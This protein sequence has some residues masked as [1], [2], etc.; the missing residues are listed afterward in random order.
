MVHLSFSPGV[1]LVKAEE[2]V[3][4]SYVLYEFLVLN[5][6]L[7]PMILIVIA[8]IVCCYGLC[9][10]ILVNDKLSSVRSHWACMGNTFY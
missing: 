2:L 5:G 9:H 7:F 4:Q 6:S 1:C 8:N 10:V 3:L